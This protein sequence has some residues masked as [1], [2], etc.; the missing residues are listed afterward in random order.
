M[1]PADSTA[2]PNFATAGSEPV[3]AIVIGGDYQGLGI[4]RSLGRRG[5]PVC[6]LDDEPSVSRYSRYTMRTLRVE[7]VRD[8]EPTLT[9]LLDATRR[10]GM[11]GWIVFPTRDETV[12]ALARNRDRLL[13]IVRVATPAWECVKHACDKRE[14]YRLAERLGIPIPRTWLPESVDDLAAVDA[15]PAVVKPAAKDPFVRATGAKAWRVDT[16]DELVT[17]FRRLE[18]VDGAGGAIVQ[19]LVPGGPGTIYGYCAL[20]SNG[21]TVGRM[22][23]RYGRQHPPDFGRS[24]TW[25]ESVGLP[26]VDEAST[27]FLA[28]IGYDGLVEI[29]YKYD[30]RDATYRLLDVNA[31]T[32]G[33]HALGSK[34]G[35]DFPL[36]LYDHVLGRSAVPTTARPGIGW[37]RLVTDLPATAT[38]LLHGKLSFRD[39][40]R[41]MI[42]VR[43][44]SVFS[45]SDPLPSLME[46]AL[47]P[48]LY[49]SRSWRPRRLAAKVGNG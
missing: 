40:V 41:S 25:V 47:L 45:A 36:M 24:A 43:C 2:S 13:D 23:V 5:I 27:R 10:F 31:R 19:E 14:T 12:A 30:A 26:E 3:G 39:Y 8:E 16:R 18:G 34:L 33:Y 32:W 46:V 20:F 21:E 9:A 28:E 44:E 49:V 42:H 29:E 22:A 6:V 4:V 15:F 48:H 1:S 38:A 17:A 37:V 7:N 35:V 11:Q